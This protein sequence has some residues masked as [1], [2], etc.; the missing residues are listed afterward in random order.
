MDVRIWDYPLPAD[1]L[2]RAN[3]GVSG[4]YSGVSS[5]FAF[6]TPSLS[7]D[8]NDVFLTLSLLQNAFSSFGGNTPNQRAV[9]AVLR[10]GA[11]VVRAVASASG[12]PS[13]HLTTRAETRAPLL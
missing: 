5:N 1:L 7:Y 11:G 6:L 12:H 8:A 10:Y 13:I 3:G 9:G 2:L 4:A